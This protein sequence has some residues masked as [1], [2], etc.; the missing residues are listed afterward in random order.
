MSLTTIIPVHS[1]A[2]DFEKYFENAL[3]S[4]RS[5]K[6]KI[7]KVMI[8]RCPCPDVKS[9][10][11]SYDFKGLEVEIVENNSGKDFIRQINFAVDKVDTEYFSY[12]EFDDEYSMNWY[13]NVKQYIQAYNDVPLFLNLI[14]DTDTEGKFAG[15][16]NEPVWALNFSE[17]LGYLDIET[18]NSYPNFSTS[19]MVMKTDV[20]KTIGRFKNL[21]LSFMYELMLRVL[22]NG[23]KIMTIPKIGYKHVNSRP[24]SMFFKYKND[25]ETQLTPD[26]AKFWME[27]AKKEY[28]FNFDRNIQYEVA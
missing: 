19:G 10:L 28:F 25:P 13:K 8:V 27:T 2:G 9:V 22:H 17:E 23:Y 20:F 21:K 6:E 18:L 15:F 5:Q 3:E 7:D 11:E 14:V 4:V 1:V 12:L 24:G 16:S 26:E